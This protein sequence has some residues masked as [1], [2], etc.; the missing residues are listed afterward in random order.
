MIDNLVLKV[1]VR[2]NTK[3]K[4]KKKN[5]SVRRKLAQLG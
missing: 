4:K 2:L 1:Q 3:K 5:L